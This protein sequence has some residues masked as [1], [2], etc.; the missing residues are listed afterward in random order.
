LKKKSVDIFYRIN[1]ILGF[2]AMF[3]TQDIILKFFFSKK[4]IIKNGFSIPKN[5]SIIL[6]PTHRSRWDGLVLTMAM[7]RRVTQKDCRFMVT[8]S[9]MRG[10]QGWFLKRLGCFSINQLSPSL[11][12][13]RYAVELI[14]KGEQLVVFPEGKINRYGKELVLKEGLYR[15]ARLATKKTQSVFI[16]PIGIAYSKV[17]PNFRGKFCL[18]FGKPIAIENYINMNINEFNKFLYEK[19]IKEEEKA[20]KNVGR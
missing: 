11:S 13:L 19:M 20:L 10:I 1:P 7:G 4:K 17:S 18:S 9:E 12:A 3:L 6:A 2:L 5:S 16:L 15:L 8:R 14:E